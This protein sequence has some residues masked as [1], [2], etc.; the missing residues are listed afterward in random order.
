[1]DEWIKTLVTVVPPILAMI[2]TLRN[3]SHSSKK[4]YAKFAI[5]LEV[6]AETQKATNKI[7]EDLSRKLEGLYEKQ[8]GTEISLVGVGKTADEALSKAKDANKKIEEHIQYS[9]K[10]N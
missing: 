9:F 7:Q 6:A 5:A 1:M 2:V 3:V 8:H 4:E 10:Q